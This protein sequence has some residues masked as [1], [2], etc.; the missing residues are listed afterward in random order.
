MTGFRY[1][2]GTRISY[3]RQGFLYF[4]T[5]LYRKLREPER[6][7]IDRAAHRAG[8]AYWNALLEFVTTDKSATEIEM[9]HYISRATLYRAV[10]AY[11]ELLD[12]ELNIGG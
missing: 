6:R 8:K 12:R 3:N 9:Q 5:K 1:R 4:Y 10:K 2:H 7:M 11:Y